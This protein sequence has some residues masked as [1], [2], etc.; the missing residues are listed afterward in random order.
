MDL[1]ATSV[2]VAQDDPPYLGGGAFRAAPQREETNVV[3]APRCMRCE[4]RATVRVKDRA[5]HGMRVQ[6]LCK[7]HTDELLKWATL[8]GFAIKD[9]ELEAL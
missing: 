2:E 9:I 3:Q 6:L 7:A 5:I 1:G 4:Q 8:R